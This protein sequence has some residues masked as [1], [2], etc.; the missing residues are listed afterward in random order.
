MNQ[1]II[2]V[3]FVFS[4]FIAGCSD[5][6]NYNFDQG[7][8][9]TQAAFDSANIKAL[10]DPRTQKIP[11]TNDVLFKG[12]QDG[13]L[14][15]PDNP[16]DSEGQKAVKAALNHLDGFSTTAPVT[17]NFSSSLDPASIKLGETV[18]VFEVTKSGQQITGIAG[19][20]SS[21][22]N[23]IA[24]ATG[25]NNTTL[26]ILPA[27]PLKPKTGYLVVLTNGLKGA[28]GAAVK[29]DTFYA[30][31]KGTDALTGDFAALEPLRQA[32]NGLEALAGAAGV[33]KD[34]IVLSWTFTTQSIGDVM[35]KVFAGTQGRSIETR[36]VKADTQA[37]LDAAGLK[38]EKAD[39]HIG[40][41][42]VPYYLDRQTA[43]N[44]TGPLTGFWKGANDTALTHR[45]PT[46]V[47]RSDVAIPVLITVPKAAPAGE[48]TP[49][50][51][52]WPVVIFQHGIRGNRLSM[53]KLADTYAE[54]GFMVVSIDLALHGITDTNNKLHA[55]TNTAFT[56]DTEQN[57]DFVNND[58]GAKGPDGK[59]DDSGRY[60]INLKSLLTSRDNIRQSVSNLFVLR[61]SLLKMKN[62]NGETIPVDKDKIRFVGHSLGGIVGA[63]FLAFD[64]KVG[65]ASLFMPGGGI[66]PLLN[67]SKSFGPQ[68][69][70]GLEA[71]G[72]VAG[73]AEFNAF[74]V[75]AQTVLDSADPVNLGVAA[76]TKHPVHMV[77]VIGGN[78]SEPDQVIPNSVV[79]AP[80]SGTEP[81]A[82]IMGLPAVSVP[83][84]TGS[85]IVRFTAGD[86]SSFLLPDASPE[87]T[88]EMHAETAAF[89]RSNGTELPV[90]AGSPVQ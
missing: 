48:S 1:R 90:A 7:V 62:A 22:E 72:I 26:A 73:T 28:G 18:R 39:I 24:T 71:E 10:F 31:A 59:P 41:L 9:E 75:A 53:L 27:Q 77:E 3:I 25:A 34:S 13:T 58:T 49:P 51:N 8:Q 37:F 74:L 67:G 2:S 36:P 70:A 40:K 5:S 89:L 11:L 80:L 30:L 38:V 84:G 42:T 17:A 76:A 88:D 85:G 82:A 23:L 66:A 6:S 12:T 57:L 64:D 87:A 65:A 63:D 52:G 43:D 79:G 56:D 61:K 16:Q 21:P 54:Q 20:L 83:G 32:V 86:H 46:P 60:F 45:N 55:D 33:E 4:L 69:R 81:L 14:N 29:A 68:I 19:E 35:Q 78:S 47:K 50:A 15:I 44:P